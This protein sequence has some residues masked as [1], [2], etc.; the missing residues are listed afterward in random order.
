MH[1]SEIL[2]LECMRAEN[3]HLES[4]DTVATSSSSLSL[5]S[6]LLDDLV[7]ASSFSSI[8]RFFD[9]CLRS[10]EAWQSWVVGFLEFVWQLQ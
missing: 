2:H 3:L 9:L 5:V 1:A 8:L 10:S 7:A 4:A 6:S